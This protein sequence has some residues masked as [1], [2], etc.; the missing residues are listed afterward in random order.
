MVAPSGLFGMV[1]AV[2]YLEQANSKSRVSK[3]IMNYAW[4]KRVLDIG[5]WAAIPGLG[6]T[7][8]LAARSIQGMLRH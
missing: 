1:L 6:D 7:V 5:T 2:S 8:L 4:V 3:L